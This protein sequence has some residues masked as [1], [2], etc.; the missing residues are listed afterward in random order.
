MGNLNID[1][2][3]AAAS[4]KLGISPD[5]LREALTSGDYAAITE[6]LSEADRAKIG[7]VLKD[8]A[9]S[10]KFRNRFMK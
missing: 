3:F 2:L 7:A 4:E 5:R 10:E 9:L 1:G 8:P 6:R